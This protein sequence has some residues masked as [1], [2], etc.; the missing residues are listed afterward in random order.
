MRQ[1]WLQPEPAFFA[2]LGPKLFSCDAA[3]SFSSSSAS[4]GSSEGLSGRPAFRFSETAG[5]E[6]DSDKEDDSVKD[7][8][9]TDAGFAFNFGA[10]GVASISSTAECIFEVTVDAESVA[11]KAPEATLGATTRAT[12]GAAVG[13]RVQSLERAPQS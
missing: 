13:P 2:L 9:E 1:I 7:D 6:V 10:A 3:S 5:A 4:T 12:L 8:A 11:A